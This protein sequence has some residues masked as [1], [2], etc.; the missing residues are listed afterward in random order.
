MSWNNLGSVLDRS[1]RRAEALRMIARAHDL[2]AQ[3]VEATYNLGA[4]LLEVGRAKEAA[5]LLEEASK[6]RPDLI[7]AR[8]RWASALEKS[9]QTAGA[10]EVWRAIAADQPRA[11]VKVASLELRLGNRRAARA[12]LDRGI[13][14]VGSP[15]AD[16]AR[17]DAAL[18]VLLP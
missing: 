12:A 18:R 1:G 14:L 15:L 17:R 3:N 5:P 10:L 16:V 9:E 11:W 6:R 13:E 8:L 4:L 2:D 7:A